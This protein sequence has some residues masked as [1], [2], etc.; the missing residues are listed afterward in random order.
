M[1][2]KLLVVGGGKMGSALVEGLLSSGWAPP[3][4]VVVA[5]ASPQRRD[6]LAAPGGPAQRFGGLAIV[7]EPVPAE[8]AVIAV[9]PGDAQAA[10]RALASAGVKRVLSVAAG[11]TLADLAGWCQEATAVLRAMPNTAALVGASATALCAGPGA[12][13]E[14]IDW[15]KNVM[16]SVG[17]VVEVPERWMNAVTGLSGSG[18]AYMFVVV[19]A[20]IEAGV[21]VGLPREVATDLVSQTLAGCAQLLAKTGEAP[22]ALRASVTSPGGT[23]AAALRQLE[24]RAVRSA[25][26]EAV[27]AATQRASELV[28]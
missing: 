15:A 21:L 22:A 2:A 9:K 17:K 25:F 7:G 24:A 8:S 3:S 26:V 6:E 27:A 23:T 19:E 13:A 14:D 16:R 10:C 11:V 12:S 4:E 1:T 18:P 20:M 28:G 5:E